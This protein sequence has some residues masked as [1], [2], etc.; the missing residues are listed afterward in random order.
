MNEMYNMSIVTHNF[1]VLAILVVVGINFYKIYRAE[2]AFTFRKFN[3]VFNPIGN[4]MIGFV[5]MTGVVMM[6]A[7]HLDFSIANIIMIVF[8]VIFIV[9]EVKRSKALKYLKNSDVEGFL[10][11]QRV[12][13][14]ILLIEFSITLLLYIGML[15]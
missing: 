12:A 11:Y 9:L 10:E 7:K 1:S 4:S 3:L 14:K 6:A 2:E 13:K 15:I 5:I 8:A